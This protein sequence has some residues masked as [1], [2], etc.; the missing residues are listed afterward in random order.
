MTKTI[1]KA[2]FFEAVKYTPHKGQIQIH[3][4]L[5]L[6]DTKT[7][8]AVCG[9]RFGKSK[10]AAHEM[11]YE[12]I[13]PRPKTPV[14]PKGDFMGWIVGP[15][16]AAAKVVFTM[17]YEILRD[18]VKGHIQKNESDG[19]I[20][21]TNMNGAKSVI[22]RRTTN[23]ASGKGKLTSYA[24]DFLVVDEGMKIR[25]G[26]DIWE[27][28]LST[29]LIDRQGRSLH[30]STPMGIDGYM[31]ELY[32]RGQEG[33][34]GL[35]S[36]KMPTWLNPYIPKAEIRKARRSMRKRAFD[37]EYG[38]EMLADSGMVFDLVDLQNICKGTL[39]DPI[40]GAEYFGGL[41]LGMTN[42]PSVL[43]I[44]RQPL[45]GE[46]PQ[47]PRIVF[48]RKFHRI[49]IN[50]QLNKF[51]AICDRYNDCALHVDQNGIGMSIFQQMVSA[52]M[53]VRAVYTTGQGANAK[54]NQILH[55]MTMV[56]QGRIMLPQVDSITYYLKELS[57][58]Q[59]DVTPSGLKTANAPEGMHDDCVASFL[60]TCFWLP[61][62]DG[63][64]ELQ[65]WHRG[66]ATREIKPVDPKARPEMKISGDALPEEVEN[67]IHSQSAP[68]RKRAGLFSN[69]L[70]PNSR[71][72]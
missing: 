53:N 37:Q 70:A 58:Y 68:Q 8:V 60:L 35:I 34:E 20:T 51:K 69:P 43:T 65:I 5:D 33:E 48:T 13:Y 62:S 72:R 14:N 42:D 21:L 41:D 27:N 7:L 18:F 39:E 23:D 15:D 36:M 19:T 56:E 50:A 71:R 59:W 30:I 55:A 66:M 47:V 24:V 16:H 64:L 10:A 2:A 61:P 6:P 29:R 28:Q 38:A 32:R 22:M 12:A 49:H 40:E 25:G 44:A 26:V 3:G 11:A 45:R 67:M 52:E 46:E 9:T 57:V 4:A 17:V 1:S 63:N 31:A 54:M